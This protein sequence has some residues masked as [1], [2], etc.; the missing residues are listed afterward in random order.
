MDEKELEQLVLR[1]SDGLREQRYPSIHE[2]ERD[3]KALSPNATQLDSARKWGMDSR[4]YLLLARTHDEAG[5]QLLLR[6]TSPRQRVGMLAALTRRCF[7]PLV[8]VVS[9]TL[10]ELP[11]LLR[12]GPGSGAAAISADETDQIDHAAHRD[13]AQDRPSVPIRRRKVSQEDLLRDERRVS[14]MAKKGIAASSRCPHC[15]TC[16][17]NKVI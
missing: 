6:E 8:G 5:R 1:Y 3:R 2:R 12:R 11:P 7:Y 16:G 17:L 10:I 13:D 9:A 4:M 15:Q 14:A